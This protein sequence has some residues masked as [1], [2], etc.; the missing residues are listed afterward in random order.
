MKTSLFIT[1]LMLTLTFFVGCTK[2]DDAT[3]Y[4]AHKAVANG[5]VILDVR[6]AKEYQKGHVIGAINIP[7]D[8]IQKSLA[9]VPKKKVIVVYCASGS[10]SAKATKILRKNGWHVFDVKTA[11][12]FARE[13]KKPNAS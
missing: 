1:L 2:V 10:R 5:A 9:T 6:S 4:A 11:S 8:V 7:I 3:L 12:E 13:V